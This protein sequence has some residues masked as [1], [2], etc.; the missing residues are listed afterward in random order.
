MHDERI[1]LPII[2]C[3]LVNIRVALENKSFIYASTGY[4]MGRSMDPLSN[5]WLDQIVV[6]SESNQ[7]KRRSHQT[8]LVC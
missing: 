2:I 1:S 7:A 6:Q 3:P 4:C 8:I 5:V